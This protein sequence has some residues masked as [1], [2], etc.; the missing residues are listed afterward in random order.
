MPPGPYPS[1]S[2]NHAASIAHPFPFH[3]FLPPL[4][5]AASR[6][7]PPFPHLCAGRSSPFHP[8]RPLPPIPL[9]VVRLRHSSL[10]PPNSLAAA[11]VAYLATGDLDGMLRMAPP[12]PPGAT[13]SSPWVRRY[14]QLA[15]RQ[16]REEDHTG[17]RH[18]VADPG[19]FPLFLGAL[20]SFPASS[21]SSSRTSPRAARRLSSLLLLG[22]I[23]QTKR[24]IVMGIREF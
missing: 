6:S 8:L 17:A 23:L 21:R 22:R 20:T 5:I 10:S 16:R 19:S 9:R 12:V 3:F 7:A 4:D 13:P 18:L 1:V 14:R 15:P 2:R 24:K 11:D